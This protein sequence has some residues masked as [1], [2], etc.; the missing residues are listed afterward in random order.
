MNGADRAVSY[1]AS[2][3]LRGAGQK[4][5]AQRGPQSTFCNGAMAAAAALLSLLAG[6]SHMPQ[7][8]LSWPWHH[9][10]AAAP[11]EV[12]ELTITSIAEGGSTAFPQYWKRNTLLVDLQTA[13]GAGSIVLK[14]VEG[15][16]WP[17]RLAFRVMPGQFGILEVRGDQRMLLPIASQGAKP[18]DLE[19]V[20]GVYTAKTAQI[21]VTWEAASPPAP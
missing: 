1:E 18:L 4:A 7:A 5:R 16:T 3:A 8:H 13:G 20:P 9:K 10:P 21:T 15:T 6:C 11:Q 19:L 2:R 17:V 14:P 12:H